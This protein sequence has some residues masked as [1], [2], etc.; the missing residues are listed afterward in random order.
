MMRQI[1]ITLIMKLNRR[2]DAVIP[3]KVL[4][5][6]VMLP[7]GCGRRRLP[8]DECVHFG[9]AACDIL[10]VDGASRVAVRPLRLY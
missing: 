2:K 9:R 8:S 7:I 1:K 5:W 6:F 10:V 3:G 4:I